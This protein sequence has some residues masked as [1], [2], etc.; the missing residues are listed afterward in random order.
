MLVVC[1]LISGFNSIGLLPSPV[2]S[3]CDVFNTVH[4]YLHGNQSRVFLF[5]WKAYTPEKLTWHLK[6]PL[7]K[8]IPVSTYPKNISQIGS[9]PKII[10]CENLKK[11]GKH[12]AVA[13]IFWVKFSLFSFPGC[14]TSA[15]TP[16]STTQWPRAATWPQPCRRPLRWTAWLWLWPWFPSQCVIMTSLLPSRELTYQCLYIKG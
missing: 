3:C 16:S 6:I 8:E 13:I 4:T 5:S 12:L 2:L 14:I 7:E 1:L 15:G 10:R 9:F 11:S